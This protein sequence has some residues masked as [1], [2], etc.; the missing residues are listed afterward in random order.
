MRFDVLDVI[1]ILDHTASQR[2]E[3]ELSNLIVLAPRPNCTVW[4][5]NDYWKLNEVLID[6]QPVS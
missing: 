4:F 3:S 1:N 5:C 6:S 2:L